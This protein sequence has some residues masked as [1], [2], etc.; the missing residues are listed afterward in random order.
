[1][2]GISA[3]VRSL[4]K[5]TRL[6]EAFAK[7]IVIDI[8]KAVENHANRAVK[9]LQRYPPKPPESRYV[10]TNTLKNLWESPA[11]TPSLSRITRDGIVVSIQ[12]DAID[13]RGQHYSELVH[14]DE[15]GSGQLSLHAGHGWRTMSSVLRE[16]YQQKIRQ[17]VKDAF[18]SAGV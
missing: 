10:R 18:K 13:P 6:D 5:R 16:G 3:R 11:N 15:G 9:R 4:T 17:I 1:M 14:G 7:G 12:N 2:A 8:Q